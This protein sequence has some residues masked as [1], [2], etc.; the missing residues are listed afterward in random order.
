MY[1]AAR[2]SLKHSSDANQFPV[3][4][5]MTTL[6]APAAAR[7]SSRHLAPPGNSAMIDENV[8]EAVVAKPGFK[9]GGRGIILAGMT[10]E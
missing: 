8:G 1:Q 7:N 3:M 4:R 5:Q 9:R 2:N 6:Q 10:Y